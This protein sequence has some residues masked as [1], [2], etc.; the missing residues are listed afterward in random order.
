M[1]KTMKHDQGKKRK[2]TRYTPKENKLYKSSLDIIIKKYGK[3]IK[4]YD[5]R[6]WSK[7]ARAYMR[8]IMKGKIKDVLNPRGPT[9]K[10]D[11][12]ASKY[13]ELSPNIVQCAHCGWL[14]RRNKLAQ[15]YQISHKGKREL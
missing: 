2:M 14:S 9:N 7:L 1:P 15:H 4:Q 6:K 3:P 10:A 13:I 8:L 5:K 12:K 11:K